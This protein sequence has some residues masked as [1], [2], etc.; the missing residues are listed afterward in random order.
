[1]ASGTTKIITASNVGTIVKRRSSTKVA[2]TVKQL[3]YTTFR[4]NAAT[5]WGT[6]QEPVSRTRYIQQKSSVSSIKDSDLVVSSDYPW[7][8]A[9]PDGFVEDSQ[10]SPQE[11]IVD[12][13]NTYAAKD[14]TINEAV[15]TLKDFCLQQDKDGLI[16]LCQNHKYFYQVQATMLC[17]KRDWCDFIVCTSQDM[18]IERVLRT[19][20][21]D[22]VLPNLKS[23]YF[24]AI[25][26]ELACPSYQQGGIRE[27]QDWL[28]NSSQFYEKFI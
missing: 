12:F 7:L 13:K 6:L 4:G 22:K 8:A 27:P 9:N 3:L 25:L 21:M 19:N 18:H 20:L 14:L 16:S 17:T 23:F 5:R 26:P 15:R 28:K 11:G 2:N 10:Y 24:S 1:M